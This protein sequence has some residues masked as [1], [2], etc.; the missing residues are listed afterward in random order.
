[1]SIQGN[2]NQLRPQSTSRI[3][4]AMTRFG[5]AATAGAVAFAVLPAGVAFAATD[6]QGESLT[7]P[8]GKGSAYVDWK[9]VGGKALAIWNNATVS[10]SL[11]TAEKFTQLRVT[12]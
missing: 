3:R 9:A 5:L 8:S 10:G 6:L 1:M 11:T 4:R 12:A 7:V 2:M